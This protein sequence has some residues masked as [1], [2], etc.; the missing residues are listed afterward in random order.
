LPTMP[1]H[2]RQRSTDRGQWA[3]GQLANTV[4]SQAS[5]HGFKVAVMV[6]M[7]HFVCKILVQF[8]D[9]LIP[10][11]MSLLIV[12][13]LEPV[14]QASLSV[15]EC[16]FLLFF[17]KIAVFRCCLRE[18]RKR[19]RSHNISE[20]GELVK[21]FCL[22]VSIIVTLLLAGRIFWIIG[23]IVWLSGAA[24][25]H[26]FE[27]YQAGVA[28]RQEQVQHLLAKVGL[29]N[30]VH[31]D[32]H[33][34]AHYALIVLKY[35]AEFLTTHLFYSATQLT[36]T[37]IFTIFLL[38]SPVQR[39]FS[40]VMRGVFGSMETYLKLKTLISLAMAITNGTALALMG[41][42]IPAAWGLMTFL[43][44]FIPN[45]G[46]PTMSVLPCVIALLDVRKTLYQVVAAFAAQFFLHFTIANF[47]EPII[48]GTTEAIHSVVVILGL[49]FF[50]YMWGITGMFLSVPLL[51]AIHAWLD[52]IARTPK[53]PMEARE[54]ARFMMG[55]LEGT[56]LSDAMDSAEEHSDIHLLT[57]EIETMEGPAVGASD[58]PAQDPQMVPSGV[59]GPPTAGVKFYEALENCFQVYEKG[60]GDIR[61]TGLIMRWLFL[62]VTYTA[63]F[64]GPGPHL[65]IHPSGM[66]IPMPDGSTIPMPTMSNA[67]Y[68]KAN[69]TNISVTGAGDDLH[70][71]HPLKALTESLL[72]NR[73]PTTTME[74]LAKSTAAATTPTT[75]TPADGTAS[76]E[77]GTTRGPSMHA[78]VVANATPARGTIPKPRADP[79]TDGTATEAKGP[80]PT[81]EQQFK[82]M[83]E[84]NV[85]N[86]RQK[87]SV[88]AAV[89]GTVSVA[90]ARTPEPFT[91]PL[92]GITTAAKGPV[93]SKTQQD[94]TMHES[95]DGDSRR[96]PSAESAVDGTVSVA[97]GTTE[98][99]V[100]LEKQRVRTAHKRDEADSRRQPSMET[101]VDGTVSVAR[102]TTQEE[103]SERPIDGTAALAKGPA[104][105]KK[106]QV[107]TPQ[108]SNGGDSSETS[109]G[110]QI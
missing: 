86:S 37:T 96:Q 6:I 57:G 46:G 52:T 43:A 48:F 26:D 78:D 47:V 11:I 56:W 87:P 101:A 71:L 50:G 100:P 68:S 70:H 90:R 49:S 16:T 8:A 98:G 58:Y 66:G 110:H 17:R 41:L 102:T 22:F 23:R 84:S 44:N 73:P 5:Y 80:A 18:P 34:I 1:A 32:M 63:L 53:Y 4:G 10:F 109:R 69:S 62:I 85:G 30:K 2:Q 27:Y 106:K 105:S 72:R 92:D 99:P 76:A 108:E 40:P 12:S 91:K 89:D 107:K 14:K 54:D 65:L 29:E 55:M 33:H 74:P 39:D 104:P 13:I 21:R 81:K 38:Y 35:I 19:T 36:L 3:R 45:I 82:S 83:H 25:S 97:R 94:K 59:M 95:E 77:T 28:K 103:S 7:F 24:I 51:F 88:E 79:H 64:F 31:L 60:T 67:H 9:I 93:S 75:E 15:L 42:E 61:C 20:L